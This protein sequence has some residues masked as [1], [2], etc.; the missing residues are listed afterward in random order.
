LKKKSDAKVATKHFL[1]MVKN[2]YNGIV[3]EWM[4]DNRGEYIDQNYVK[5]LKDEGIE[6]Q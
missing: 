3:S 6:I 1:A 4:S 5:L 2:Q